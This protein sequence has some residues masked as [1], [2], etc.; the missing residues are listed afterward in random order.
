MEE[1]VIDKLN[2]IINALSA[3][4]VSGKLNAQ[5]LYLVIEFLENWK[6]EELKKEGGNDG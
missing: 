6:A 5:I 3:L 4:S 1:K 2:R